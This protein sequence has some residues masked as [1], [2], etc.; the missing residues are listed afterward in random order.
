M[1]IADRRFFPNWVPRRM[2]AVFGKEVQRILEKAGGWWGTLIIAGKI[3][4]P[5]ADIWL[6][7][8]RHAVSKVGPAEKLR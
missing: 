1:R 5:C 3:S 6:D 7:A 2:H 8:T 4:R